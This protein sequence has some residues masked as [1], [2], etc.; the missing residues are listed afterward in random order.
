[1][2][3]NAHI[4]TPT[5]PYPP[6]SHKM[7]K[8]G[9][10]QVPPLRSR[11][12]FGTWKVT[13]LHT[14]PHTS[15]PHTPSMS[16]YGAAFDWMSQNIPRDTYK[17]LLWTTDLYWCMG[18][19]TSTP[20]THTPSMSTYRMEFDRMSQ[21]ISGGHKQVPSSDNSPLFAHGKSHIHNPTPIHTHTPHTHTHT[22]PLCIPTS[23]LTEWARVSLGTYTSSFYTLS[24][25]GTWE[26]T[27]CHWKLNIE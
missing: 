17:F 24:S 21:N 11:P 15:H 27:V 13:H 3:N 9:H 18:S 20:P 8:G 2:G 19:H 25:I 23:N 22:P 6:P 1:M 16:T 26:V 14:L 7:S 10:T 5:Y 4:E 12:A